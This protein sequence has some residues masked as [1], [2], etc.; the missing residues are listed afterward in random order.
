MKPKTKTTVYSVVRAVGHTVVATFRSLS[1]AEE[2]A[3]ACEQEMIDKGYDVGYFT[4]TVQAN[5]YYDL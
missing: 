3:Q 5:T 1:S 4:F 2:H